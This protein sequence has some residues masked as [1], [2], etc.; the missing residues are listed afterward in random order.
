MTRHRH[1]VLRS[2]SFLLQSG[3]SITDFDLSYVTAGHI[4]PD[5][6]NVVIVLT[7]LG[8]N[9]HR[10]DYLLRAG[11]A[12]DTKRWFVIAVDAIGNGRT[13]SPSTSRGQPG[14]RFP[15]FSIFD[16]YRSQRWLVDELGLDRIRVVIGASM[17]GMQ[18]LQWAKSAPD[19]VERVVAMTPLV[20]TPPWTIAVNTIARF[21]L[22][23]DSRGMRGGK[24]H[25]LALL[26]LLACRSPEELDAMT[27]GQDAMQVI[28]D[29]IE[30]RSGRTFS[31][32]DWMYQSRAYDR[33]DL[34]VDD[35]RP[36]AAILQSMETPTLLIVP[37]TDLYNPVSS[38]RLAAEHMPNAELVTIP[39]DRGHLV[40]DG[41]VTTEADAI[42]REIAAFLGGICD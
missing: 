17:G 23:T 20:K 21:L 15:E 31:A 14:D 6:S 41:R 1:A 4:D 40:T 42:D 30:E 34:G 32:V 11:R 16:M 18:A 13:T 28:T 27:Q 38:A 2:P 29:L 19:R 37:T 3:E 36:L 9:H 25:A 22:A 10:L 35:A 39:T 33:H 7:S 8:S 5:G 12:L 26:E 24:G